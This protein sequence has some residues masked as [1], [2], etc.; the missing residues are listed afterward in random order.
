MEVICVIIRSLMKKVL[1]LV[2]L[3]AVVI[4]AS[5]AQLPASH[6]EVVK[7]R[8]YTLSYIEQ[9]E[10]AEWIQYSLTKEMVTNKQYSRLSRFLRDDSVSTGSALHNDYTG[11][12][13]DRG[14]LVPA[15]DMD[16]DSLAMRDPFICLT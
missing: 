2:L 10:Q 16:F 15:A 14:H 11:S 5:Y 1:L 12:G 6:G 3:L 8:Y 7:H 13:F 9:Y 4:S